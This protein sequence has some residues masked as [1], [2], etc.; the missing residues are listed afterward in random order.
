MSLKRKYEKSKPRCV[1][2]FVDP[3]STEQEIETSSSLVKDIV[4]PSPLISR[5]NVVFNSLYAPLLLQDAQST[6]NRIIK[7]I[8]KHE[9]PSSSANPVSIEP[10]EQI[11]RKEKTVKPQFD[12]NRWFDVQFHFDAPSSVLKPDEIEQ[13]IPLPKKTFDETILRRIRG[14]I[15]G[16]A[17]GDALGAHVEW[18]P[19]EYLLHNPVEDLGSGGTWGLDK[20][21]VCWNNSLLH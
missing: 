8:E 18:R 5:L 1:L 19:H 4:H 13:Q 11:L 3:Q 9:E 10:K 16:M 6:E 20:G 15:F 2:F 14:S 21:Q 12:P 17:I 7:T